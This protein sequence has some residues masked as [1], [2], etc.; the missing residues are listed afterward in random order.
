[1]SFLALTVLLHAALPSIDRCREIQKVI[2]KINQIANKTHPL[3]FHVPVDVKEECLDTALMCF[4]SQAPK[5]HVATRKS[6][7]DLDS[8]I[9]KVKLNKPHDRESCTPCSNYTEQSPEVFL[10]K[11]ELLLQ[12]IVNK[13]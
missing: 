8:C 13:S 7:P 1:M 10:N 9:R 4:R 6:K 2:K 12:K 3:S 5:L 11:M